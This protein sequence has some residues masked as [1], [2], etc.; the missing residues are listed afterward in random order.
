[1]G[2]RHDC[3]SLPRLRQWV[4]RI[5]N[6]QLC[7]A[8]AK[9]AARRLDQFN[10]QG[11]VNAAWAF[12][13]EEQLCIAL[14]KMAERCLDE[15]NVQELANTAWAFATVAT[16]G[17]KDKQFFIVLARMA[18]LRLDQFTVQG[19]ANTAWAFAR[20]KTVDQ[21]DERL[22]KAFAGMAERRLDQTNACT[23]SSA[24]QQSY[25]EGK[26]SELWCRC[27]KHWQE[28]QSSAWATRWRILAKH[29]GCR[30]RWHGNIAHFE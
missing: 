13:P 20:V 12:V 29:H 5:S 15:F 3:D 19:L 26:P 6:E 27:P 21:K 18:E 2:V 24:T 10:E 1:M 7:T 9:M 23:T 14:A 16:V 11:L 4:K 25:S 8:V 28:W 17:Q 30:Q 22:F